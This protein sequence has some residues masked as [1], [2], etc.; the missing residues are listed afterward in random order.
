MIEPQVSL[1]MAKGTTPAPTAE[2]EPLDEPPLQAVMSQGF[3]PGPVNEA[4]AWS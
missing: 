1:P 3:N 4:L 2:P